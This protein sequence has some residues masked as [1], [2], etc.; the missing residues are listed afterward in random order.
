MRL[1]ASYF[2]SYC[3]S[4]ASEGT[5]PEWE[6]RS[7]PNVKYLPALEHPDTHADFRDAAL[8]DYMQNIE[9]SSIC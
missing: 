6:H 5:N 3:E 4:P 8:N 7:K 2:Q 1:L 9:D